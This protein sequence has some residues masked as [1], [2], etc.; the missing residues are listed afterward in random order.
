VVARIDWRIILRQPAGAISATVIALLLSIAVFGPVL[1]KGNPDHISENILQPPFGA[2]GLGT[3]ELG[4]NVI[5]EL[6]YGLRISLLVGLLAAASATLIGAAVGSV[7]GYFG[8]SVD[9]LA[10]RF[11]ES[12]QVLPTF[13]LAALIVALIGAGIDRVIAVIALLAWP[14]TARLMRAQVLRVKQLDFVDAAR[15]LGI[16]EWSIML[17]EVIPNAFAPVL[18]TATLTIGDAILIEAG[19]SYLGLSDPTVVSWGRMLNSG[20]RYLFEA[21]WLSIFPGLAIFSTVLVFN[22]LGSVLNRVLN[23]RSAQ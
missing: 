15:C 23:P 10:M 9:S 8:K 21:W 19:L 18:A 5:L 2:F 20:Q 1:V 13:I 6:F 16:N 17:R 14:Q 12:F 11:S 4:R 22:V 7:A 3:D